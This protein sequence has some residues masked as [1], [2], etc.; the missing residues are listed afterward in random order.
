MF[1]FMFKHVLYFV[2]QRIILM[3]DEILS[4]AVT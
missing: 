2:R 3:A 4:V 1:K